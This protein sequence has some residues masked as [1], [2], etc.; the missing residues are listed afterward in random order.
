[1]PQYELN[2]RDYLR[3]LRKR[4]FII[5]SVFLIVIV[6]TLVYLS[7]K[8]SIYEA[9]TTVKILQHKTV[10]GLLTEWVLYDPADIMSSQTKII[11]GF[12]IMK[13]VALRLGVTNENFS[14][15]K[16]NRAVSELQN[17]IE[18]ERLERTNII[19]ITAFD[20]N[21]KEAMDLANTIAEVYVDE[22]LLEKAMQAHNARLFIEEQL[23]LLE[24]KFWE[25]EERLS[26]FK[27]EEVEIKI[28]DTG[29]IESIQK[30][31]LDLQVELAA[32][33]QRYTDKHPR[34]IQLKKQIKDLKTQLDEQVKDLGGQEKNLSK[35]ELE[36]ARL[37]RE[38]E[39]N[40]K[41]Y[42]MLK[43]KLA[44]AR[45]TEA[46]TVGDVSIVDPA[47]MPASPI[48]PP[49]RI[50]VIIGGIMGLILG[51]AFAFIY[52]MLDTSIETI[53]DVE[54]L[55]K[56]PVL[57]VIPSVHSELHEQ[58]NV[59]SRF[60]KRIFGG[61]IN[62]E[63]EAY[64]RLIV[65]YKPKSP[66]AESYRNIRTN[67]KLG[68][69]SRKTIL[70]TSAGPREGKTTILTNLGLST[71]QKGLKTL[72]VSSDLRR[73]ALARTFGIKREPG[74]YEVIL[75]TVSLEE[76]LK[77]ISDIM[78]GNIKFDELMKSPGIDNIS[79]LPSGHLPHNP[80]EILESKEL[81]NL[82]EELKK[83][84][85]VIFFDSPPLLPITDASLL[86]SKVDCVVLCYE[87]GK[88]AR[89]ALLRSKIQL[90]IVGSK[91]AGV[92]LNH[93]SPQTEA[94]TPYPYYYKYKYSY[95][96]KEESDGIHKG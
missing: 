75:G 7:A 57:G 84:F 72:L 78:L 96:E 6:S 8:P 11:K 68:G 87:I 4:K 53:E 85:D 93:I 20:S 95:T 81:P 91:I 24:V 59:I 44:E 56:L 31:L 16:I 37:N 26:K 21:A 29:S 94:I 80:S 41:L 64:I 82:I 45:I 48:G 79:V 2:L 92:I 77:N 34:I 71:A 58:K 3:I 25:A 32:L 19:R 13:K 73:P 46:Q 86:A 52:E 23:S 43:E 51:I 38:V 60:K 35:Q 10:A 39:V 12:P 54:K 17:Q 36:Y 67:L 49:K 74:F 40:E 76:G 89:N 63:E 88:T 15:S 33:I 5:I 9:S 65:H 28:I 55:L 69:P 83:R 90:E 62:S 22:S 1:M 14:E 27:G 70:I 30:K 61:K 47:V 18:T 50:G 66:I 42:L